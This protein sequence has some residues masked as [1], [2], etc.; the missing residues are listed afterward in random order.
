MVQQEARA[1]D[2]AE[3]VVVLVGNLRASNAC[4][5]SV[6]PDARSITNKSP[7]P[8]IEAQSALKQANLMGVDEVQQHVAALVRLQGFVIHLK[9]TEKPS[10]GSRACKGGR[11]ADGGGGDCVQWAYRL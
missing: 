8:G 2:A 1:P 6:T 10:K 5:P 11:R 7:N 3:G 4:F 9:T